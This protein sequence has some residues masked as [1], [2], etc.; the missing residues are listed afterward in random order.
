MQVGVNQASCSQS[1]HA[2]SCECA[3]KIFFV[4]IPQACAP[5]LGMISVV[6]AEMILAIRTWAV[7]HC[8]MRV[9]LLLGI[10]QLCNLV[11]ACIS[12]QLHLQGT[13]CRLLF[14]GAASVD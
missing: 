8:D 14:S 13:D 2:A 4:M 11:V 9:G 5:G 3:R 12:T 10:L 6:L 1:F 7:C